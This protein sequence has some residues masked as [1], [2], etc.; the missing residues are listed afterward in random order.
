MFTQPDN[1]TDS[2]R[3]A[4]KSVLKRSS[5]LFFQ[6]FGLPLALIR[7][8]AGIGPGDGGLQA[9]G[10]TLGRGNALKLQSVN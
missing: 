10:Q 9:C 5:L 2:V 6:S 1:K 4:A 8:S 3:V 7:I